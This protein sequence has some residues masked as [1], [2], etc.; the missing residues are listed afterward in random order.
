[1]IAPRQQT[2]AQLL[3]AI[4]RERGGRP[5]IAAMTNEERLAAGLM[6][7]GQAA[8]AERHASIPQVRLADRVR[9]PD[10]DDMWAITDER[11]A[12]LAEAA[13]W[14]AWQA[15]GHETRRCAGWSQDL[16]ATE[17]RCACGQTVPVPEA[18]AA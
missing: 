5:D 16:G 8:V 3:D 11:A 7:R 6:T 13:I 18:A 17:V 14:Q 2:P 1:M 9:G 4:A 12:E 10:S 15:A